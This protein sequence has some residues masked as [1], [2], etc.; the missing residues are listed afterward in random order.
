[1]SATH[2]SRRRGRLRDHLGKAYPLC[3]LRTTGAHWVT[4]ENASPPVVP[5]V[6]L[7]RGRISPDFVN[8]LIASPAYAVLRRSSIIVPC[9][10]HRSG[11]LRK[12]ESAPFSVSNRC[13]A[14]EACV[15]KLPS[16]SL[17]R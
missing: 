15:I 9:S 11:Y 14:R 17:R 4:V 1:M 7:L 3:G 13:T 2:T 8:R 5:V 12:R 6:A 10:G 16:K